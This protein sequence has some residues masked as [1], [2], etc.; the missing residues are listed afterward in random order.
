[1]FVEQLAAKTLSALLL[2]MSIDPSFSGIATCLPLD[3]QFEC[4][5]V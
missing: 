5:I 2:G 1:M 4:E 3:A